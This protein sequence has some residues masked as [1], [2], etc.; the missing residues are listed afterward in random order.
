[1]MRLIKIGLLLAVVAALAVIGVRYF[2]PDTEAGR[3]ADVAYGAAVDWVTNAYAQATASMQRERLP[4]KKVEPAI[5]PEV[6]KVESVKEAMKPDKPV[7][8][9]PGL[10][11]DNWVCG[12]KV[13]KKD[14]DGKIVMVFAFSVVSN[15][16]ENVAMMEQVSRL[17]SSFKHHPLVVLGSSREGEPAKAKKL[18]VQKGATF[19]IY[20]N[21]AHMRE[22]RGI[23]HYPYLYVI[24]PSGRYVYRG[25]SDRSAIEAIV[26][27][28]DRMPVR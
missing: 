1:M 3:Y 2:C 7:E 17:W 19:P 8:T 11:S 24:D 28:L 10:V 4:A 15:V 5:E 22:P 27:A 16:A 9:W 18:A 25:R 12:S 6:A 23:S 14:L 20:E 21:V 26:N 13:S